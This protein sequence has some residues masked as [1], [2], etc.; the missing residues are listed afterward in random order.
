MHVFARGHWPSQNFKHGLWWNPSGGSDGTPVVK[1][2]MSL[3]LT[4]K[5]SSLTSTIP[6]PPIIIYSTYGYGG[7]DVHIY[8]RVTL[9]TFKGL[10]KVNPKHDCGFF[11]SLLVATIR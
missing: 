1:I 6:C 11:N 2:I 3:R 5:V 9:L 10:K 7:I 8:I 4:R